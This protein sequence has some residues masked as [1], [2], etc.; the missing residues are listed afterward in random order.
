MYNIWFSIPHYDGIIID[1][2]QVMLF[3]D[4]SDPVQYTDGSK[5]P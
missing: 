4:S 3:M 5:V 2:V 1:L